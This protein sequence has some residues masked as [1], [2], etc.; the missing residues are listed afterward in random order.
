[1]HIKSLYL[2]IVES[3]KRNTR[4]KK[5]SLIFAFFVMT[6]SLIGSYCFFSFSTT[7]I[8]ENMSSAL[9]AEKNENGG[10]YV[11][12]EVT[13]NNSNDTF[14]TFIEVADDNAGNQI[15]ADSL[16]FMYIEKTDSYAP[17][18]FN[19]DDGE[20]SEISFDLFEFTTWRFQRYHGP[21]ETIDGTPITNIE[22]NNELYLT[23]DAALKL[24]DGDESNLSSLVGTT[25]PVRLNYGH[26][27]FDYDFINMNIAGV[28][29]KESLS[30]FYSNNLLSTEFAITSYNYSRTFA[31]MRY[32]F[33]IYGGL[34]S[35]QRNIKWTEDGVKFMNQ[36]NNGYT[37]TL[38]YFNHSHDGFYVGSLEDIHSRILDYNSSNYKY[39]FMAIAI[40][41]MIVLFVSEVFVLFLCKNLSSIYFIVFAWSMSVFVI[42]YL[43]LSSLSP[44]PFIAGSTMMLSGQLATVIMFVALPILLLAI[45]LV[46]GK[47]DDMNLWPHRLKN[48]LNRK[49]KSKQFSV[50]EREVKI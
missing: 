24:A 50:V 31:N 32:C 6:F 26:F 4:F 10:N 20:G 18:T 35:I 47:G 11:Y 46:F 1:M 17:I 3:L 44:I 33:M 38:F 49:C 8:Y 43:S 36:L 23:Y 5:V 29:S 42:S 39:L 48:Y 41:M 28:I 2:K 14:R 12:G 19:Y 21:F 7:S 37:Y 22:S 16:R 27:D 30:D 15:H 34:D 25:I 45:R 9:L 13:S 40:V